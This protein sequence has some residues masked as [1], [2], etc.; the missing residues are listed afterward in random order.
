MMETPTT[1]GFYWARWIKAV[2]G[3]RDAD[4]IIPGDQPEV[5]Y[6][7]ENCID[8]TNPEYLMVEVPGVERPQA[9]D[10]FEWL[11]GPIPFPK[12][13]VC[14]AASALNESANDKAPLPDDV[15][16]LVKAARIV[17]YDE[18]AGFSH[19]EELS[20]AADAFADRVPF[21]IEVTVEEQAGA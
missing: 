18:N 8:R 9:L 4:E 20:K 13:G 3:T 17:I 15:V 1:E 6:V 14:C 10:C 19:L 5:M 16:R 12:D 11:S 21:G 2:P 7:F